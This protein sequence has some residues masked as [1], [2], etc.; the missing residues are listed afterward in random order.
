MRR[1]RRNKF[2]QPQHKKNQHKINQ[3]IRAQEVRVI[4]SDGEQI[5]IQSLQQALAIATEKQLDLVEI[6]PKASPPVCKLIDYGKYKYQLQKKEAEAKKKQSDNT[7]KELKVG[8]RTDVG[9]LKTKL[10]QARS[11]I[12]NGNKV[13]FSMRFRGRERAFVHL[14]KDKL[15]EIV[16]QLADVAQIDE[17]NF[18][19]RNIVYITVSPN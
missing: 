7:V 9:D 14:G 2:I 17:Q 3:E 6:A 11:F 19:S 16:Q 15:K 12:S 5:G 18:R 4:G 8:Y 10:K 13:K 1:L